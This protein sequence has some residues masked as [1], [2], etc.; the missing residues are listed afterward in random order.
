MGARTAY[1]GLGSNL[2]GRIAN[3][4][5]ALIRL[6]A[7][8]DLDIAAVSGIYETSP[9]ETDGGYFLNAVAALTGTSNLLR[10]SPPVTM[11]DRMGAIL[12]VIVTS[13][14]AA[15]EELLLIETI[16]KDAQDTLQLCFWVLPILSIGDLT[17]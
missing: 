13:L 12:D 1:I 17:G 2:G 8:D 5:A 10:P 14:S 7:V 9:V 3:L 16:F 15:R 4:S 11:V 6:G